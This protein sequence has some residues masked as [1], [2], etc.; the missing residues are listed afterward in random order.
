MQI[1]LNKT[2]TQCVAH[3]NYSG[4]A[5]FRT[6][7]IRGICKGMWNF[8]R[9]FDSLFNYCT[10]SR[11]TPNDVLRNPGWEALHRWNV[12]NNSL[13]KIYPA[14]ERVTVKW[15]NLSQLRYSC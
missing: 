11:G 2:K 1:D 10:I 15:I 6:K 12:W 13:R 7:K 5:S 3:G 14:C 8:W 9:Y 4:I